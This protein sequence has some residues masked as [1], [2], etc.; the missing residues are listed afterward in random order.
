MT[1]QWVGIAHSLGLLGEQQ[2]LMGGLG[3]GQVNV[4]LGE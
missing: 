3:I 4:H 1:V 2:M